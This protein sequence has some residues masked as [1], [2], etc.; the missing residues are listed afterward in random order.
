MDARRV[1][2]TRLENIR[3]GPRLRGRFP[4]MPIPT[5]HVCRHR[6]GA[7]NVTDHESAAG[8]SRAARRPSGE[9]PTRFFGVRRSVSRYC[10]LTPMGPTKGQNRAIWDASSRAP[11]GEGRPDGNDDERIRFAIA[12]RRLLKFSLYGFVRIAEPHDYGIRNGAPQLLIYQVGGASQSGK[13][14]AW[15]WVI[16]GHTMNIEVLEDGFA[17][18]RSA[19]AQNHTHWDRLFARVN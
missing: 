18:T 4:I 16:L 2:V 3:K 7:P 9:R 13:L 1:L 6:D 12:N 17:G 8:R 15:R 14:P 11:G 10:R 19:E 5:E